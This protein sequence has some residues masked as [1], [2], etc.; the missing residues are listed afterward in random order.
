MRIAIDLSSLYGRNITG[1]EIYGIDIYKILRKSKH[2][3]IPIFHVENSIDD[4]FEA[5]IIPKCNRIWLE[6]VALSRALRKIKADIIIF[7]IFPPPVDIY[8]G[9]HSK[10]YQTIHDTVFL[11][12]RETQNFAAKYYYG[13]KQRLAIKK[14]NGIIT[15][16]E[17]V[18]KQ[19]EEYTSLPIINCG[20]IIA[21]EYRNCQR[22]AF[23][24]AIERWNLEPNTYFI[25]VSTIEPRKNFKYL[26][27][28]LKPILEKRKMKLVLVGRKGW[29]KDDELQ[30]LIEKM[31]SLLVFPGF[32]EFKQLVSLY[33]YAYAFALLSL[34][35]GFGRTPYEAVACGCRRIILSDIDIFHETFGDNACFLP[36]DDEREATNILGKDNLPLVSEKMEV[37]FDVLEERINN[38]FFEKCD[39][40]RT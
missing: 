4:N 29:G 25:S 28:V 27:K 31:G 37:P 34:D 10:I 16:S 20:N 2:T 15:I 14:L 9:C 35:E 21:P 7:P 33:H 17:T 12:Y 1:V 38:L 8:Y 11:R 36:L 13:L 30:Q 19:L 39:E 5:Y 23:V 26:I 22:Q 18:K 3:I 32:V 6:N 40:K 24:E